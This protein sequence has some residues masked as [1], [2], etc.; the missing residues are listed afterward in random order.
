MSASSVTLDRDKRSAHGAIVRTLADERT[1]GVKG[2][3]GGRAARQAVLGQLLRHERVL[4]CVAWL[5][6]NER[7]SLNRA[8]SVPE[9]D[10]EEHLG[11]G[12]TMKRRKVLGLLM[13]HS[14]EPG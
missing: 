7:W 8:D 12:G 3:R 13:K 2:P 14:S 10:L 1:I 4:G 6:S 5:P 9:A 11:I